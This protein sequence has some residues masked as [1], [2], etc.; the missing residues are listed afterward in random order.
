MEA[1]FHLRYPN[2]EQIFGSSLTKFLSDGLPM[3][4]FV[5]V[6][7]SQ[8]WRACKAQGHFPDDFVNFACKLME[9]VASSAGF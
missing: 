2:Q 9:T 5:G 1:Q 7:P 6:T 8:W 3:A 4:L